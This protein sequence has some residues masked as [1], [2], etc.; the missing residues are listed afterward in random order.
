MITSDRGGTT[1][2][3]TQAPEPSRFR[4]AVRIAATNGDYTTP[5]SFTY[6]PVPDSAVVSRSRTAALDGGTWECA[7]EI[8]ADALPAM[9]D[10][11]AYYQ[12]E[13]DIVDGNG[14]HWPYFTGP[15]DQIHDAFVLQDGAIVQTQ[16]I[17]AF[18]VL[19]R[20]KG[21]RINGLSIVPTRT[22]YTSVMTGLAQA[23]TI[24][25]TKSAATTTIPGSLHTVDATVGTGSFP[26]IKISANADFSSPLTYGAGDTEYQI[27]A[28]DGQ[29]LTIAWGASV[30]NDTYYVKF[31]SIVRFIVGR[32]WPGTGN[33]A[34]IRIPDGN[35]PY[36][37]A[38]SIPKRRW[39]DTFQTY[40]ASGC[41]TTSITVKDPTPYE[42]DNALVA[43][44]G[45]P[46]EYLIWTKSD[47]TEE[48]K[49]ISSTSNAGV[50]T[51][52]SAF[53]AAPAE[54]DPI[55]LGT[56]EPVRSWEFW[57]RNGNAN[58]TAEQAKFYT[59]G[60]TEYSRNSFEIEPRS[61]CLIPR[62]GRHY[63][64]ASESV[65]AGNGGSNVLYTVNDTISSIGSDNRIE[66]AYYLLLT[67]D[68]SAAGFNYIRAAD[69]VSDGLSGGFLKSLVRYDTN[70]DEIIEYLGQNGL[71]PGAFCHDTPAG[72]I[73]VDGYSQST[74]PDLKLSNLIG[75]QVRS[76]PAPITA[77][78]VISKGPERNI[79]ALCRPEWTAS[80]WTSPERMF[81]GTKNSAA[82]TST[83]G[84]TVRLNVSPPSAQAFPYLTGLRIYGTAGAVSIKVE[85]YSRSAPG[86][87]VRSSM[88]EG[89]GYL[90]LTSGDNF[91]P[92]ERLNEALGSL[93]GSGTTYHKIAI[94]FYPDDSSGS[95]DPS[96]TE[97]EVWTETEA[98]WTAFLTDDT[99]G[100]PPSG[101][102]TTNDEGFGNVWW[103]RDITTPSSYRFMS[104]AYA[105]R[106]LPKWASGYASQLH[107]LEKLTQDQITQDECRDY[108]ERYLDEYVRQGR[109]YQVRAVLDPRVDLGDTVLVDLPDGT[110]RK[111]FV[112]AISDGGGRFDFEAQYDLVDY[113]A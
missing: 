47:G 78:S 22:S 66:T 17:E 87:I 26:G 44:S 13:I 101:W 91:I 64:S 20:G 80:E 18:G 92:A 71:P 86:T 81:D 72:K 112:W 90:L 14:L 4:W 49:A 45:G 24:S 98:V 34:F 25:V 61:G 108:A 48:A 11:L 16:R 10:P 46:T 93:G 36:S 102:S 95:T 79:A 9:T 39:Y 99:S 51:L 27:T 12:L 1:L 82:T 96:I 21:Q 53:S 105:K 100:S 73:R 52:S 15:I 75:V 28:T 8:L 42:S 84:A 35:V 70:Y 32:D 58:P 33:P 104:A 59:G 85:R 62:A 89:F 30:G 110:S 29:D 88:V 37:D 67:D 7:V 54:G 55:R 2:P 6:Y 109:E 107:R 38:D 23:V 50:I 69:F 31:W 77:V 41:T 19:N 76:L 57:N 43:V 5:S 63:V 3:T 60:G 56:T 111:L 103:Q 65:V 68:A 94:S 74:V 106:V 40:A 113:S 83:A 97:I